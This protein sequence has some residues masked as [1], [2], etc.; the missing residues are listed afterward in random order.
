MKT[1]GKCVPIEA[2]DKL[3]RQW[4]LMCWT[5]VV[6]LALVAGTGVLALE[7]RQELSYTNQQLDKAIDT[8]KAQEL[9]DQRAALVK[10]L[11]RKK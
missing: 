3:N 10:K 7:W 11:R 2:H 6:L 9:A 4:I 8:I 5:C 1:C